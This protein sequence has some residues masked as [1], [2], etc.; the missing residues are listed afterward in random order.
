M[1]LPHTDFEPLPGFQLPLLPRPLEGMVRKLILLD[2]L[3]ELYGR[4]RV[5]P[6]C[7]VLDRILSALRVGYSVAEEDFSR[8][9]GDGPVV[10][11][12]N[13]PFGMLE[14]AILGAMLGRRRPDVKIMANSILAGIP[15]LSPHCIFVDV[16]AAAAKNALNLR[17]LRDAITW[18]RQGHMLVIFPAGEVAH[19]S[20]RRGEVV[21]PGWNANIARLMRITG[22]GA[23]PM[24]VKGANTAGFQMLGLIHPWLR[25]ASL[26]RELLNKA[27]QSVEIRIGAV[28]PNRAIA[29]IPQDQD[30]VHYLR[31]R[32]HL[33]AHR[34]EGRLRLVPRIAKPAPLKEHKPTVEETPAEVLGEEIGRLAPEQCLERT[35]EQAVFVARAHQIPATLREIGR[36]REIAFRAV[37]EGTGEALD[38]DAFD[39]YYLHLF[40]WNR[41][42]GEVIGAYRMGDTREILTALGIAGLYTSTLFHFDRRFFER[43]GP[44]L[45]LGRSFVRLEYQKQYAPLMMLWKG[46][47]RYIAANP[48]TPVLFGAVSISNAY[49]HASRELMVRFLRAQPGNAELA[50]LIRPRRPFRQTPFAH[51]DLKAVRI[52][53]G[54]LEEISGPISDIEPDGKGLPVLLRQYARLGGT[55]LG[56][57]LDES[58]SDALDGLMVVDLR[59]TCR[60]VLARYM[61]ADGCRTFLDHHAPAALQI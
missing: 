19:W 56:F 4:I 7:S 51:P 46:V 16:F 44:A 55:V 33:L 49:C 61:G 29:A 40:L 23:L 13:H 42:K 30:A 9:P 31:W 27:G 32:A 12:S 17:A 25:T 36:L 54:E 20:L 34:D 39:S 18:L 21:D 3:E 52:H 37:G 15:E 47:G 45:E 50:R 8:I 57:N 41:V 60:P 58:F 53:C 5:S 48:G 24:F 28:I 35:A 6:G 2:D 22:A 26:P 38:L 43:L 1:P 14:G 10:A 59:K 11:V